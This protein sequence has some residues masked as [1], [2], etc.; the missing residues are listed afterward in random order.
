MVKLDF[1]RIF[2][3]L[4]KK[5]RL[6]DRFAERYIYIYITLFEKDCPYF[7]DEV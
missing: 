3:V 4:E 5:G 1:R 6:L 2:S 7:N